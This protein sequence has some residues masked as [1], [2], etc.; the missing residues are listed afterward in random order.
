[1]ARVDT[2]TAEVFI[3]KSQSGSYA[4]DLHLGA[5][6]IPVAV[7]I[8]LIKMHFL[9]QLQC[10]LTVIFPY[11]IA[12][13]GNFMF[14]MAKSLCGKF[15]LM[16]EYGTNTSNCCYQGGSTFSTHRKAISNQIKLRFVKEEEKKL[17][18]KM[19]GNG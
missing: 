19:Q 3:F 14:I 7:H 6:I 15:I 16:T 2:S 8:E 9:N 18:G 11:H 1:M 5:D 12:P 4:H 10:L 17:V 13:Y